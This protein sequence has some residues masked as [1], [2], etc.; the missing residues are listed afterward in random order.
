MNILLHEDKT[1]KDAWLKLVLAIP[2]ILVLGGGL[3]FL[4]NNNV[5]DALAMFGLVVLFVIVFSIIVPRRYL[6]FD[7]KVKIQFIRPFSFSIPFD[8][9]KKV[10]VAGK[11]SIGLNFPSSL[12]SSHAVGILRKKRLAAY[13]TPDNR[14]LFME[15]LEKAMSNWQKEKDRSYGKTA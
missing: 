10:E 9:I 5:E 4:A 2:M 12:S 11:S 3:Q 7:D 6:I 15:T 14:E 8:T 1:H 13:I